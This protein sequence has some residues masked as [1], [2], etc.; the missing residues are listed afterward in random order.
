MLFFENIEEKGIP[1]QDGFVQGSGLPG[2]KSPEGT[3]IGGYD[4]RDPRFA[5]V[6]C[7]QLFSKEAHVAEK[8]RGQKENQQTFYPSLPF[9]FMTHSQKEKKEN[10]VKEEPLGIIKVGRRMIKTGGIDSMLC[11]EGSN[12]LLPEEQ[13]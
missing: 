7:G 9:D 10:Q 12:L 13:E 4:F 11:Q 6:I 2:G 5:E 8:V 1:D 3:G